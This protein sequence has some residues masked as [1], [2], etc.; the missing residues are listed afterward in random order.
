M[1][2]T[3]SVRSE[4]LPESRSSLRHPPKLSRLPA[5]T[6][7]SEFPVPGLCRARSASAVE[8]GLLAAFEHLL[9]RDGREEMHGPGDDPGPAGLVAGAEAGAVVAVE[10]FVE[11]EA[12]A[13]VRVVLELLRR[14]RRR[15]PAVLVVAGRC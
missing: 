6:D 12:I 5:T 13:P 2:R 11:Q 3:D 7:C 9:R 15:A 14:R 10:V 8:I 1:L 4:T